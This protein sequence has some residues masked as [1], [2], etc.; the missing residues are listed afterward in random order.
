[1]NDL[2]IEKMKLDSQLNTLQNQQVCSFSLDPF[3]E[4]GK[5]ASHKNMKY[6][7]LNEP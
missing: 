2:C 5:G 1:M 7:H 4:L 6:W 3:S